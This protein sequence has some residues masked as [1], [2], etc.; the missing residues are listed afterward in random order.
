[1]SNNNSTYWRMEGNP[2]PE[3]KFTAM[4]SLTKKDERRILAKVIKIAILMITK[5]HVY[6]FANVIYAKKKGGAIGLRIMGL[7]A[8]IY[9]DVWS[10]MMKV[11]LKENQVVLYNFKK[12]MDDV[13]LANECIGKWVK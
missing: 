3:T 1:M 4:R 2:E 7:G 6:S 11:M 8:R 12:Y 5:N 10:R 13:N 9:M